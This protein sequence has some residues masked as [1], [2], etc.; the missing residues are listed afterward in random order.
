MYS[1]C[2]FCIAALGR[3]QAIE[4][5]PV[6]RRLAYDLARGRLWV[7]CGHCGQ[8]NLSPLEERWEAIEECERL[9]RATRLRVST[10]NIGL[11][12]V[13]DGLEL[14]RIGT[15]VRS[16]FAAWR[17]G[18]QLGRRLNQYRMMNVKAVVAAGALLGAA[19]LLGISLSVPLLV[20][21][22]GMI[23]Y[24]RQ[25]IALRIPLERSGVLEVQGKQM[26]NVRLAER[27]DGW[28]LRVPHTGG[29]A[30]LRGSEAIRAAGLILPGFN[31]AGGTRAEV[32]SAVEQ[33]E[34]A[35]GAEALY[36]SAARSIK[37]YT[38]VG[39]FAA[40]LHKGPPEIR[41]ALEM[42]AHEEAEREA[43]EGE[44]RYLEQAW[45]EA[46][47]IAAIADTLALPQSVRRFLGRSRAAH[48]RDG[49]EAD[50]AGKGRE[51][52]DGA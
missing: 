49:V 2:L 23:L 38:S 7:V 36:A 12:R 21:N 4:A 9:F 15:P 18:D 35:G 24:Y 33:I 28:A 41:L 30:E 51:A 14:V 13:A 52:G 34:R 42:A 22:G 20:V 31:H 19:S 48:P 27:G 17:Y 5:F 46:E 43:L 6:G 11:G 10:E 16:E 3:N 29:E 1:A 47:Q 26:P 50:G 32:R 40:P 8:W 39:I 37:R 44:L 45:K 25:R